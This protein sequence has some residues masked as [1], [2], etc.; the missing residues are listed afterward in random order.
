MAE[1]VPRLCAKPNGLSARWAT[2][3]L[4]LCAEGG[5]IRG[6]RLAGKRADAILRQSP[7]SANKCSDGETPL[8]LL[9]RCIEL[10]DKLRSACH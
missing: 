6:P 10:A 5:A 2:L 1:S 4:R 7:L 3:R 8:R 9:T